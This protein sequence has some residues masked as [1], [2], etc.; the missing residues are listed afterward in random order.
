MWKLTSEQSPSRI[1]V[2]EGWESGRIRQFGILVYSQGTASSNLA[3]SATLP[4][5]GGGLAV[6]CDPQPA[7]VEPK[8]ALRELA[9]GSVHGK[10]VMRVEPS[11]AHVSEVRQARKGAAVSRPLRVLEDSLA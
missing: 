6:P 1:P 8:D 9:G 10:A 5:L 11:A 4:V 2:T 7:H 3:P